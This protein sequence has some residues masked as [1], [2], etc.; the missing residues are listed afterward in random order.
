MSPRLPSASTSRPAAWA[1]AA[2]ACSA[3]QPG[4]PRRS[5]HATWGLTAAQA[6]AAASMTAVQWASTAAAVRSAG[7]RV[8]SASPPAAASGHSRAGS[9]SSPRTIWDS[10]ADTT[11]ARRSPNGSVERSGT[12]APASAVDGLLQARA[13]REPRHLGGLDLDL[14]AGAGVHAL[15]RTALGDRELAEA[16]ERHITP[17]LQDRKSTR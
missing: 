14:L 17:A 4:A 15:A 3:A 11:A 16:G 2:T 1:W 6:G 13:R 10:R 8:G 9:G 5:K 7:G 12:T